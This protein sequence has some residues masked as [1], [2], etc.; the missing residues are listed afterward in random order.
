MPAL[1]VLMPVYNSEKYLAEAMD[2]ILGQTFQDFEFLII[3]DGSSDQ[4]QA[5]IH[6]YQDPRIRFYQN[7]QNLGISQTLNKGIKLANA[8]LI[9]RMDADDI[10]YPL[11]L[12]K[13][14]AYMQENP[15]CAMVSCLVKVITENGELVR[16][17]DFKSAYFYYN[18]TFICWI[19]H[20][21]V[22]YRKEA[23]EAV[24][25]YSVSY[26]ED[27]D[28]FWKISRRYKIHNLPEVL[29]DY[30]TT[31]QSLHQ[32]LK[33][34]EYEA[35]QKQQ[36]L[37]NLRYYAGE[38]YHVSDKF[39][40]CFQ[41]DFTKILKEQEVDSLV[42]CIQELDYVNARIFEKANVNLDLPATKEAAFYKKE[43]IVSALARKLPR[44][45]AILFLLK[46]GRL[47]LLAHICLTHLTRLITNK[48]FPT[49]THPQ[50]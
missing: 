28:L 41:H 43:F 19:Y 50:A 3:D 22:L 27:F 42:E 45:T 6:S 13:Q 11:R 18:L 9:A 30:R 31:S 16:M 26:A 14:Y 25:E 2:S 37:R 8:S 20:P 5:I 49:Q 35:A 47:Q 44:K 34:K 21:T 23:V 48:L 15:S 7:E 33:K 38:E 12:E 29:L 1:T 39:I 46:L 32:V 17:D 24:G 4:S 36:I 10:S 40:D